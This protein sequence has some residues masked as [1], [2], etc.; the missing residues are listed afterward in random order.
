MSDNQDREQDMQDRKRHDAQ[1]NLIFFWVA[2]LPCILRIMPD[3]AH[4][5]LCFGQETLYQD[6]N[7]HIKI[8]SKGLLFDNK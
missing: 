4:P 3:L 2:G 8:G 6:L 7:K 5:I 1:D